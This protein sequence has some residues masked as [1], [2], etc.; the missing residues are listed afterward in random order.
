MST[1]FSTGSS[2]GVEN[3]GGIDG[4]EVVYNAAYM[5]DNLAINISALNWLSVFPGIGTVEPYSSLDVNVVFDAADLEDGEYG[6]R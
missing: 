3:A 6:G 4:L 2:I 5:H 1:V